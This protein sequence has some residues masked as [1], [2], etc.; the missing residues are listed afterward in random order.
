MKR[1]DETDRKATVGKRAAE[2]LVDSSD[3]LDTVKRTVEQ[4]Y[5]VVAEPNSDHAMHYL[6]TFDWRLYRSSW[7]LYATHN[8]S[9]QK[10]VLETREG[11][12]LQS[13][14]VAELPLFAQDLP[15]GR[16]HEAIGDLIEPRRLLA[17]AHMRVGEQTLRVLNADEKTVVRLVLQTR[18]LRTSARE[19]TDTLLPAVV[20]VVPVKGY[21]EEHHMLSA[22]LENEFGLSAVPQCAFVSAMQSAGLTPGGYKSKV[23]ISLRPQMRADDAVRAIHQSLLDIIL[24][25]ADGVR[26]NLDPEF[27]HDFRV[28]IRAT[29]SAL[30]QIKGVFPDNEAKHFSNEFKWLGAATGSVRDLD[31]F[32]LKMEAFRA[33][34]PTDMRND[35]GPLEKYL[36]VHHDKEHHHLVDTL[37]SRRYRALMDDWSTFLGNPAPVET[38]TCHGAAQPVV[39]LA[40][41]RIWRTYRRVWRRARKIDEETPAEALHALRIE[42][43]KLRYLLEFFSSLYPRDEMRALIQPLKQLQTT[44]GNFNDREVQQLNLRRIANEMYQERLAS[45][46]SLLAM[47]RL[48][49]HLQQEQL[50]EL[51]RIHTR[52]ATF[53]QPDNR[54]QY[55]R[56]FKRSVEEA[57]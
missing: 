22:F 6:D 47:G 35:L 15:A 19:N 9:G 14:V 11:G 29:R 23:T 43:K 53:S 50:E 2:F 52:F 41:D 12:M 57:H 42:C 30:R 51:K 36:H 18:A 28:A 27:L 55:R 49:D 46:D 1:S 10:L 4:H 45:A 7:I 20:R 21:V 8:K 37:D 25:N 26:H 34:L 31:V 17:H 44:L 56:T 24:A 33:E 3:L 38:G 32:L 40:S 16:L 5:R 39:E 54:E 48:M 13:I